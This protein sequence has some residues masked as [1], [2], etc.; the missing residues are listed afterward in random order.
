MTNE[1][2]SS[3]TQVKNLDITANPAPLGLLGFG[4]TT[5][6]LNLHN[7]GFF[8]MGSMILAMGIFYGGLAQ[9][10]A[11]IEEWKKNNTFGA[12]A[13]TSY[14]L[15]WMTLVALLV[16]PKMGLADA[17]DKTAMASYLAM[18]GLFTGIMFI[19]TLKANRA[20]QFVFA[21]LTI[22]FFLLAI[23]DFTG[24]GTITLIAGYE[25]IICGFSAVY[26]GLAQILNEMYKRTVA[27]L[28]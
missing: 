15:F 22:L 13:F 16:L 6:L 12:T 11:G 7:A 23:G 25:G 28:G 2:D 14:G 5:V 4:M 20:L 18:W 17:S 9:I 19:G 27:P 1:S 8:A 3:I 21:S 10:I 26:A 24:N